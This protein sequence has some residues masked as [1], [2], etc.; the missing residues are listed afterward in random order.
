MKTRVWVLG[1]VWA[2][3]VAFGGAPRALAADAPAN[4]ANAK[5]Q[6]PYVVVVGV[7]EFKD[8]AIK[9]RPTADADAKALHAMLTDP[10]YLGVHADRAKLLL[11]GDA[12]REAIVKAIDTA[13][14]S[15]SAD[16]RVV[17]A[18]FGRGT[19]AA[20]KACFLTADSTVKDRAKTALQ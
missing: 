7:G 6:G 14:A 8:A 16:D 4:G 18:F 1:A 15:T 17:I 10:K 13:F 20:D 9:P 11:S 3:V 12:T 2:L 5:P 19:S